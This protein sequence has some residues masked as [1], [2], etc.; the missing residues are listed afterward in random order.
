MSLLK[1]LGEIF[2]V[3]RE[4][5]IVAEDCCAICLNPIKEGGRINCCKHTFCLDCITK[6]AERSNHCP[7]CRKE[8]RYI[9]PCKVFKD[10]KELHNS[11]TTNQEEIMESLP[12]RRMVVSGICSPSR[13][14]GVRLCNELDQPLSSDARSPALLS[15]RH[16]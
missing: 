6:W 7:T 5:P 8:F 15:R 12:T 3:Y 14:C 9:T 2:G 4:C 13:G 10:E 11:Y 16:S 1:L